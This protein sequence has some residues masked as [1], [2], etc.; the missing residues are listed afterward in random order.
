MWTDAINSQVPNVLSHVHTLLVLKSPGKHNNT[1]LEKL[2]LLRVS[3]ASLGLDHLLG[4]EVGYP[5][6]WTD[7][8]TDALGSSFTPP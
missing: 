7:R 2:N 8:R 4:E 6:S 3:S 5:S 1:F